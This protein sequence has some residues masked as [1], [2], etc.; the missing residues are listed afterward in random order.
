MTRV[1]LLGTDDV[2]LRQTLRSHET[3]RDALWTYDLTDPYRN[4]VEVETVSLGAAISLLNDL[5]WYLVRYVADTLLRE[6]SVSE[7]EWLSRELATDIRDGRIDPD[8]SDRYLK[9][10]GVID[11]DDSDS[12][13]T[14]DE[15]NTARRLVE[16]MY[17]TRTDGSI[18]TYD[19]RDVTDTVVVRVTESEFSS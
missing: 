12:E 2:A 17:V 4:A 16:P 14:S 7:T 10:Y 19:L 1:C 15:A 18:P 5:N 8:E 3:A 11:P 6:P 13:E 9:V